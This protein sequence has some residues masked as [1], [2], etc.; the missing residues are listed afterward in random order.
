MTLFFIQGDQL[1]WFCKA[2]NSKA[3]EVFKL[4]QGIKDRQDDRDTKFNDLSKKAE[5][6]G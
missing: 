6:K 1:H 2:C 3:I 4:V 5:V